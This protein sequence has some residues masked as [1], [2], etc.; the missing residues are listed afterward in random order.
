M[1]EVT[2]MKKVFFVLVVVA[3]LVA[4]C[5]HKDAVDNSTPEGEDDAL[6]PLNDTATLEEGNDLSSDA[7]DE[8][9]DLL[10]DW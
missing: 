2:S 5:G 7:L 3:L 1:N 6:N 9:E 8:S 10:E 4:G